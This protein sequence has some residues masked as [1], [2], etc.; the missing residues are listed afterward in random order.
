MEHLSDFLLTHINSIAAYC[1]H[2]VRLSVIP[3]GLDAIL[4]QGVT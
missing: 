3:S 4:K 2:A 1:D